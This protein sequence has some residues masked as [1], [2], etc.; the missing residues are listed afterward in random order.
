MHLVTGVLASF[1]YGE[2]TERAAGIL[3]T[4]LVPPV[5]SAFHLRLVE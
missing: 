4:T 3:T 1:E 2:C 5:H